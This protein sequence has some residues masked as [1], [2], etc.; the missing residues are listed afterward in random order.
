MI[1]IHVQKDWDT[2]RDLLPSGTVVRI[3]ALQD[4][5]VSF[6]WESPKGGDGTR[7]RQPI[8]DLLEHCS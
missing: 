1:V 2:G 7:I 3:Y 5:L 4:G 6:D 8:E